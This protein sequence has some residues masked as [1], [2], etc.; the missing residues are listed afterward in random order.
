M[1]QQTIT[2]RLSRKQKGF[3]ASDAI[4][5]ALA[6]GRGSGKSWIGSYDLHRRAMKPGK[7]NRLYGVYAPTYK[8]LEDA[9]F[10]SFLEIGDMLGDIKDVNRSDLRVTLSNGS[11]VLFRSMDEPERARGPSLSG[12]WL[13]EASLMS[14]DA[15]NII[16]ACLRQGGE[17]GWLSSTFTPK[18][19]SHWTF[20][21]FGKQ[22]DPDVQLFKITTR[23][24]PFLPPEY[25]R[26][27]RKQYTSAFSEQELEGEFIDLQGTIAK[28]EWFPIVEAWP[29]AA[30]RARHW[31]LAATE[32]SLASGDPDWTAGVLIA[33]YE[34]IYYVVDVVRTRVGPG[35]VERLLLQTAQ[36]D[37][38]AVAISLEQEPGSS[39]KMA[40]ASLIRMLAGW[41]VH[42]TP[43]TGDKVQRAMPFLAQ[44]EAGNVRLVRGLWNR[45]YLDELTSFPLGNHDDQIDATAGAFSHLIRGLNA[46]TVN[47]Y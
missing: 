7:R 30:R 8:M 15:F 3:C 10:R 36:L 11:E 33:V 41:N 16:I 39:G 38:K 23:D 5:R 28:R 32:K 21:T 9:T 13:D 20:E 47:Y 37:G 40:S 43:S 42:A 19:K 26:A 6:G 1:E 31:D 14:Q 25:Y 18:G 24:N 45:A 4:Y 12:A 29:A 35:V 2:V 46:M 22:N 44:A 17:L 27:I 34:G